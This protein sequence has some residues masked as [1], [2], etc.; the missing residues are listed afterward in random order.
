MLGRRKDFLVVG[1]ARDGEETITRYDELRPDVLLLDLRMPRGDG[2]AVLQ[3]LKG[4][5]PRRA[6][7]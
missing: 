5:T 6:C 3:A 2:F 1:E 7:W 4:R